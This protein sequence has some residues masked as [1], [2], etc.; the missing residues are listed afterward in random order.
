VTSIWL[1]PKRPHASEAAKDG[2]ER[3][4]AKYLAAVALKRIIQRQSARIAANMAVESLS[5]Q[6]RRKTIWPSLDYSVSRV[7]FMV[8][9]L[10][11]CVWMPWRKKAM[12][13]VASC[14]KLREGASNL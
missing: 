1:H 9:L 8:K 7:N 4:T 5:E 6:S 3:N 2:I 13:D 14:D 11:A 12:K 10:R